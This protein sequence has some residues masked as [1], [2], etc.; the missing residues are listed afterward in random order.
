[1]NKAYVDAAKRRAA[2]DAAC[3]NFLAEASLLADLQ[4]PDGCDW[5]WEEFGGQDADYACINS[6]LGI[7]SKDD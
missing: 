3:G 7:L 1:M 5:V 2:R 6:I 4:A